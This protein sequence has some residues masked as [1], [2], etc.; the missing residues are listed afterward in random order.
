M[1]KRFPFKNN[2]ELKNNDTIKI[3]KKIINI[4]YYIIKFFLIINIIKY[5]NNLV[6]FN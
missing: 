3:T 5:Y 6:N 1:E 2:Y 4:Y